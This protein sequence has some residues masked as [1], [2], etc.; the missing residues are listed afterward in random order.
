MLVEYVEEPE[1]FLEH[2]VY[3]EY[4]SENEPMQE[5]F[6][7]CENQVGKQRTKTLNFN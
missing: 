5:N 6:L 7:E 4:V 1:D 3:V 2:L